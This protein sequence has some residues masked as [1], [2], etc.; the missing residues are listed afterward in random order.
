MVNCCLG[1][2]T[3]LASLLAISA[4]ASQSSPAS[5]ASQTSQ[6]RPG[7]AWKLVWG[8]EFNGR[9]GSAPDSKN[10]THDIGGNGWGNS[11]L[12][13]YTDR[14]P[15]NVVVQ[16]GKL[17]VR[18]LRERYIGPDGVTRAFTSARLH[19]HGRFSWRYGRVEAR[20]KI[21]SGRGIWPAFW[22][23]GDDFKT[24]GW[25]GCGE[26]DILENIG[27]EPS[28]LHSTIHGPG[29]SHDKGI[30]ASHTMPASQRLA[31][32]FHVFAV[33]WE[34]QVIRFYI[35]A[36]LFKT[37]TPADLPAGARWVF[38]HPFFVI[39]NVAVGGDWPGSPDDSTVF[40]QRMLV[41][42]VRVY[43]RADR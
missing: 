30:T 14:L 37:A 7:S 4:V 20:I 41:D 43:Q 2:R 36:A 22:M 12:E 11:E 32:D 29:Y 6:P 3:T 5:Q 38:D 13:Y 24:A 39:L 10:W 35:D 34:P 19:T 27:S 8:D 28:R 21:P 1:L 25:P 26:I 23:L 9:N 33:E 31:D 42:Y 17:E 15:T 18:A 16:D 40:P